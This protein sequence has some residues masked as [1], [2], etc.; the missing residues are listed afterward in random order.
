[1]KIP[2]QNK[3]QEQ[4]KVESWHLRR[5]KRGFNIDSGFPAAKEIQIKAGNPAP[6]THLY[7]KTMT[8]GLEKKSQTVTSLSL[9]VSYSLSCEVNRMTLSHFV[10]VEEEEERKR[11]GN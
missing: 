5:R 2:R 6:A 9:S 4:H 10:S 7:T 11:K 3:A 8:K 1:M